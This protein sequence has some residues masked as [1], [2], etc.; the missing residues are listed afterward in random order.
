M[1]V[2]KADRKES[3][4]E[5]IVFADKL[6]DILVELMRNNFGIG[7]I[8]YAVRKRYAPDVAGEDSIDWYLSLLRTAKD[9]LDRNAYLLSNDVRCAYSIYPT[10]MDEYRKRREHQDYA[11]ARCAQMLRDLGHIA[12]IFDVNLNLFEEGI[13][14][15]NREKELIKKWRQRDNRFKSKL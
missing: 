5:A 4:I 1:S 8:R 7:D 14:A 6:H 11:I 2:I 13:K 3:R 10:D 9:E 12:E 15:I